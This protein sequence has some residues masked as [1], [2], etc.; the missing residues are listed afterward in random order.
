MKKYEKK[1]SLKE[2]KDVL[3]AKIKILN[4]KSG[5]SSQELIITYEILES[6]EYKVG[7]KESL[8]FYT[9]PELRKLKSGDTAELRMVSTSL[10]STE[11]IKKV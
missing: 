10:Y 7:S 8:S 1:F 9:S 2:E 5:K 4:T 3:L 11:Y 6:D